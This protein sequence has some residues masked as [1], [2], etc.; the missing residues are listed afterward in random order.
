MIKQIKICGFKDKFHEM[1]L[2]GLDLITSGDKNGVGKSAVMESFQLGLLGE[3]PGRART[4]EDILKYT[5]CPEMSVQ[6]VGEGPHGKFCFKRVFNKEAR[7]GEKRPV[8]VQGM[9]M[10]Y[11][12]GHRWIRDEVGAV[13]LSFDPCEFLNLSDEKKIR[14]IVNHSPESMDVQWPS[15][16][17]HLLLEILKMAQGSVLVHSLLQEV[18]YSGHM[19]ESYLIPA[20]I[21][22]GLR[23][24]ALALLRAQG[25]LFYA[26]VEEVLQICSTSWLSGQS[27]AKNL[28]ILSSRLK[29][30]ILQM[31]EAVNAR[32]LLSSVFSAGV[33]ELE[34][35]TL[36]EKRKHEDVI[37]RLQRACCRL[38]ELKD[39]NFK[40]RNRDRRILELR[41][42]LA[43]L[44]RE[45]SDEKINEI[46]HRLAGLIDKRQCGK[47]EFGNL[48]DEVRFLEGRAA[49]A[50]G[51]FIA[52]WEEL[53]ALENERRRYSDEGGVMNSLKTL[54]QAIERLEEERGQV[55][56][57]LMELARHQGRGQVGQT[58]RSDTQNLKS[59]IRLFKRVVDALGPKGVLGRMARRVSP[60]LEKEVNDLLQWIDPKV[61]FILDLNDDKFQIGWSRGGKVIS[62]STLDSANFIVLGAVFLTAL[63]R[64]L[65]RDNQAVGK[66][67]LRALCITGEALSPES[68]LNLLKGL[69][70][71]KSHGH[72]DNVLITHYHSF[73]NPEILSGFREHVL[74]PE[75][76]Q[77][78]S[79]HPVAA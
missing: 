24:K 75:G 12:Q 65:A 33:D 48:F 57:R 28:D 68:L 41:Q 70:F 54:P 17:V 10:K 72:L 7:W 16:E 46:K 76:V 19:N 21:L 31:K 79:L 4:F 1:P 52:F 32:V 5:S 38:D 13:S 56:Q 27:T 30:E 23:E 49:R 11:E 6:L 73:E 40:N 26:L 29:R 39:Q 42:S 14:W 78:A 63:L 18:G 77:W 47:T 61:E 34:N 53:S 64:R 60:L 66:P 8:V 15:L 20:D 36:L 37:R 22:K 50:Q 25:E 59:R 71:L 69:S 58:I 3:I 44:C 35:E 67:T 9:P 55:E 2:S 45:T 43:D 51:M 62:F 74:T